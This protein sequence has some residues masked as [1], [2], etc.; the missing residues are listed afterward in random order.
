M[1]ASKER[2]ISINR[3]GFTLIET[4]IY[5][6][7]IG[8]TLTGFISFALL[9]SGLKNK[10]YAM[11]ELEAGARTALNLVA[12]QIRAAEEIITPAA[13]TSGGT[14]E[15]RLADNSILTIA[16]DSGIITLD[17]DGV[18]ANIT[19]SKTLVSDLNFTNLGSIQAGNVKISF[20]LSFRNADSLEWTYSNNYETAVGL[21]K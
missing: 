7:L 16:A 4:T 13:G 6:A 12:R 8:I 14:L 18:A 1:S 3:G 11:T 19:G 10:V 5:A 2:I 20:N 17:Q 9:I 15:L 21:R